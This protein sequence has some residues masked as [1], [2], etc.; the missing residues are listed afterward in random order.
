MK[1]KLFLF[2]LRL[3]TN[4]QL[5]RISSFFKNK[6]LKIIFDIGSYK[7]E[8]IDVF[9]NDH[10]TAIFFLFEPMKENFSFLKK[11][12]NSRDNIHLINKG[13]SDKNLPMVLNVNVTSN[14]S[15][16]SDINESVFFYKLRQ[17]LLGEKKLTIK[18]EMCEVTTLDQFV[19]K[20][21]LD[22][23]DL[24]KLDVEGF[25][26]KALKGGANILKKT[27]YVCVEI[28]FSNIFKNYEN[29]EVDIFLQ[30]AGFKREKSY[31]FPVMNF[32]DRIYKN[33]NIT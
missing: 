13:I 24:L 6:N 14:A 33:L 10:N 5:R 18:K 20:S 1:K 19:E 25:E 17:F 28:T 27:K 8:F 23:I 32:E 15:T 29:K 31:L 7:G 2:I 4:F 22:Y 12:F 3:L 30:R 21:N 11:K 16:F 9:E 26:L